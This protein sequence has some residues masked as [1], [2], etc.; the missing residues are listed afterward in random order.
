[1]RSVGVE[2]LERDARLPPPYDDAVVAL[3]EHASRV[4]RAEG[5]EALAQSRRRLASVRESGQ[6]GHAEPLPEHD[7]P[8]IRPGRGIELG[9]GTRLRNTGPGGSLSPVR[10]IDSRATRD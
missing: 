4:P 8:A 3:D 6:E 9:T 7:E 5:L 10:R 1:M 2:P